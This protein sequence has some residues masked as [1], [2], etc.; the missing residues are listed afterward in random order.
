MNNELVELLNDPGQ[1]VNVNDTVLR[2]TAKTI[3]VVFGYFN[4]L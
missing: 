1:F 4:F 3:A 2:E